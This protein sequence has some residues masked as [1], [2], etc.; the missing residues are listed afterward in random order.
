MRSFLLSFLN[1]FNNWLFLLSFL[2]L[3]VYKWSF[4]NFFLWIFLYLIKFIINRL[5]LSL[6]IFN[7]LWFRL[8]FLWKLF[9]FHF[10]FYFLFHI[11]SKHRMIFRFFFSIYT[12]F[13]FRKIPFSFVFIKRK[14]HWYNLLAPLLQPSFPDA[15]NLFTC[16][17][18]WFCKIYQINIFWLS[19]T[20]E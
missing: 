15:K 18:K 16:F 4:L 8:N 6:F 11:R 13:L 9:W 7:I 2:I 17:L 12:I 5:F 10:W 14:N 3:N 1:L 19:N 20:L